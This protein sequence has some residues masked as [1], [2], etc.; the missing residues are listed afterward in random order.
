[1]LQL[2]ERS[3]PLES[4]SWPK[5]LAPNTLSPRWK[6]AKNYFK[7]RERVIREFPTIFRNGFEW[8]T[9]LYDKF[10]FLK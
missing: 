2:T 4:L 9:Y 10:L 1:M 6:D 5:E 7:W 8:Y 3:F